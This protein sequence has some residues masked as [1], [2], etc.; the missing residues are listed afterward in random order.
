MM[1]TD[2]TTREKQEYVVISERQY[3]SWDDTPHED[4]VMARSKS[5]A[6]KRAKMRA[7]A[8]CRWSKEDGR[9][10]YRAI[11]AEERRAQ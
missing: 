6:I 4:T 3:K 7:T 11:L 9:I 2:N 1:N 5:E 8:E 10:T